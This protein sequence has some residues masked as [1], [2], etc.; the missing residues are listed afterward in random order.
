MTPFGW[1]ADPLRPAFCGLK[2]SAVASKE[3]Y[4]MPGKKYASIKRPKVYE[5]LK[6]EGMSK[7]K[8]AAISNAQAKKT[9][10][11]KSK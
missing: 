8:A 3:G 7:S 10:R 9:R 4:L 5:A 11:R 2:R 1:S 6:R